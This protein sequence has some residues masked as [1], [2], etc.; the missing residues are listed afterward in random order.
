MDAQVADKLLV[1][2]EDEGKVGEVVARALG[3][4]VVVAEG[5][6]ALAGP[7]GVA[8][9]PEGA[10]DFPGENNNNRSAS[11]GEGTAAGKRL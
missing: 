11:T 1:D 10:G 5:G 7:A 2:V 3:V 8:E 4:A 9:T 6:A